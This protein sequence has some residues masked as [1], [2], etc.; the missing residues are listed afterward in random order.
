MNAP[1]SFISPSRST[2]TSSPPP[3]PIHLYTYT[4][5]PHF[6]TSLPP[7]P[8]C[9]K[10][11]P[12][13]VILFNTHLST[14]LTPQ[15]LVKLDYLLR[16][17][18]FTVPPSNPS[19]PHTASFH[20]LRLK[21]NLVKDTLVLTPNPPHRPSPPT[22]PPFTSCPSPASSSS[23]Q[24][25]YNERYCEGISILKNVRSGRKRSARE[26]LCA[27]ESS[28]TEQKRYRRMLFGEGVEFCDSKS[29]G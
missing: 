3:S 13:D 26:L 15:N 12:F 23:G 17:S 24:E 22:F 7:S 19:P 1:H 20:G 6:P 2:A 5:P 10:Q 27:Q 25:S 28:M 14:S 9:R 8:S 18:L 16:N 11:N 29:R 21:R 4:S